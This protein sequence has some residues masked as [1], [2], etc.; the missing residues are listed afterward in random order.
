MDDDWASDGDEEAGL[1]DISAIPEVKIPEQTRKPVQPPLRSIPPVN[2]WAVRPPNDGH[3]A[4]RHPTRL[5]KQGLTPR[6]SR[7]DNN[8]PSLSGSFERTERPNSRINSA[9]GSSRPVTLYVT[10]LP[11]DANESTITAFFESHGVRFA[12]VR[13]TRYSDT[14]NIKAAF[15][16]LLP[17]QNVE[18]ALSVDG[19][20]LGSRKIHVKIDGTDGSRRRDRP[21]S[22]GSV[23]YGGSFGGRERREKS[24]NSW[25]AGSW[26]DRPSASVDALDRRMSDR[27]DE[28]RRDS[29]QIPDP[30]I[31]TGP[32]PAGRKKLQLKPRTKPLPVLDID[33]RAIDPPTTPASAP[34]VSGREENGSRRLSNLDSEKGTKPSKNPLVRGQQSPGSGAADESWTAAKETGV[35]RL[36]SLNPSSN[37]KEDDSKRPV[38]LNAFAAL[39][40]NDSDA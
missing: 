1:G 18:H 22:L 9:S 10:N 5:P 14:G 4:I 12:N 19:R 20:S 15:V 25:G 26:S 8:K 27:K 6:Q 3:D 40:V 13:I 11:F 38:L 2:A 23:S 7:R 35:T 24:T 29:S 33:K 31:P 36:S 34:P 17:E 39:Q 37:K 32:P 16:P 30:S 28:G 21:G